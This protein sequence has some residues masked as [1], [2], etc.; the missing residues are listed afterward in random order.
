MDTFD[1]G[2]K[3]SQK[4][5]DGISF[6]EVALLLITFLCFLV[7]MTCL[8]QEIF[9]LSITFVALLGCLLPINL[10]SN[11]KRIL[12]ERTI[13]SSEEDL[14]PQPSPTTMELIE[15]DNSL[16]TK[17][18]KEKEQLSYEN[19]QLSGEL[20][21]SSN[22]VNTLTQLLAEAELKSVESLDPHVAASILPREEFAEDL[23]LIAL[24]QRIVNQMQAPCAAAGVRLELSTSS[25][26]IS[27]QA[28]KRYISLMIR[29]I[30]DNSIKY[31]KRNG[32]LVITISN[33]GTNIFIAF[34][35]DGLGLPE[36]ELPN[37]FDL[38]FQGSNRVSGN[39]LGLAQVKAI[40][41]HYDGTIYAHSSNGMGIY[42]H[43]PIKA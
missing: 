4:P 31:M 33:V 24:S 40:V 42:I 41:E 3:I 5:R 28:D 27:Y 10:L 29:N 20:D 9:F 30:I 38:N 16:I 2:N 15:H 19:E 17:L 36:K 32:T 13:S 23:D 6:P 26:S 39:G 12:K 25:A 1:K 7:A 37:I 14:S 34:K 35:D 22:Q 21:K 18:R 11:R 8:L 43:L